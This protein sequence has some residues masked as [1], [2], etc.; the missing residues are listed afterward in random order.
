MVVILA[1]AGSIM[2]LKGNTNGERK[3]R[4]TDFHNEVLGESVYIFSPED[5]PKEVQGVLDEPLEQQETN[6][7]GEERCSVLFLPGDYDKD[8]KVQVGYYIKVRREKKY[9][10][11]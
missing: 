5:D 10:R 8:I 4:V 1:V 9:V 7:F 3:Y 2:F 6:Q 11:L